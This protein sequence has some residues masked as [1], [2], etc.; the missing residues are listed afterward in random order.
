[1]VPILFFKDSGANSLF[2]NAELE[3]MID[4]EKSKII[5][6]MY[7]SKIIQKVKIIVD[8]EG[9]EEAAAAMSVGLAHARPPSAK[10]TFIAD[11]PFRFYVIMNESL[12][13]FSGI[14]D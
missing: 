13:L 7:V 14:Y 8:E 6:R 2:E 11:K 4:Y 5:E 1:M 10:K 9:T 12:V 3:N